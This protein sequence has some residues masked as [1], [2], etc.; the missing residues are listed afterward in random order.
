MKEKTYSR[1][2]LTFCDF[3]A[4]DVIMVSMGADFNVSDLLGEQGGIPL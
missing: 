3:R 1:P 4:F 2:T